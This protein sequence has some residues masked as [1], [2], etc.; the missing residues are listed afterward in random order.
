MIDDLAHGPGL[1]TLVVPMPGSVRP[2]TDSA[3]GRGVR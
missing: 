1:A 3:T 2:A